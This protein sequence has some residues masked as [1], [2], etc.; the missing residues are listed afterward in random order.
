MPDELLSSPRPLPPRRTGV[1]TR[2]VLLAM[3][4][5]FAG[6]TVLAGWLIWDGRIAASDLGLKQAA[7]PAPRLAALP[8]PAPSPASPALGSL[9]ARLGALETQVTRLDGQA[10]AA[11]AESARAQALMIAFA[12]RRAFERGTPLGYLAPQLQQRFGASDAG[13]VKA[14]VDA[15]A[16]PVTLDDLA[17]QLD[18]LAPTLTGEGIMEGGW[19]RLQREVGQLFTIRQGTG[20]ATGPD[21]RLDRAR[22]LLRSGRTV[23]AADEVARL[24]T[25]PAAREWVNRARRHGEVEQALDRLEA[26][27]LSQPAPAA[28]PQA[29]SG[30]ALRAINPPSTG[31]TAPVR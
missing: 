10:S 17:A 22:L 8:A 21:Q 6:G 20:A 15:A 24:S 9:E 7:A 11:Q 27:A 13:A 23:A 28:S 16:T 2:A 3:V 30:Q 19:A 12:A 14:V 25:S 18:A 31:I 1:S 4:L 26:L 5:A 29:Q